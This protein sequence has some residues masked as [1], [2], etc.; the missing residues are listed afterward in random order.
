MPWDVENIIVDNKPLATTGGRVWDAARQCAQF[1]SQSGMYH[2]IMSRP[3]ARLLE[4][5]AGCGWLGLAIANNVAK[6]KAELVCLTERAEGGGLAHLERNLLLNSRSSRSNLVTAEL[7]WVQVTKDT[8]EEVQL[9]VRRSTNNSTDQGTAFVDTDQVVDRWDFI[10][11]SDLVYE[12]KAGVVALSRLL[13]R[14]LRVDTPAA[15]QSPS[16]SSSPRPIA[17]YAHTKRRFELLDMLFYR[18]LARQG[19]RVTE[20]M[21]E[22]QKRPTSPPPMLERLEMGWDPNFPDMRVVMLEITAAHDGEEVTP[23]DFH[24]LQN[25]GIV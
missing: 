11:G 13:G 20:V 6:D 15:T 19:L 25:V 23:Y 21:C 3:G 18:E 16:S 8:E 7:D 9:R 14:L 24:A 1:L 12:E 2:E 4:L 5:G 17:L 22:G 10:F